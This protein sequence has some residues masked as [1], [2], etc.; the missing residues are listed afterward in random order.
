[1]DLQ[2]VAA[3]VHV[4]A[5]D[6][7]L[8]VEASGT[9]KRR[10]EYVGA[11]RRGDEDYARASF[12][13]VHLDEQL[14]QRLLAFV[15]S[16]AEAG[17]AVASHRVYFV[18]EYYAGL[19]FARLLE[20]VADARRADADEHFDEVGAADAEEGNVG[21]ARDGS[22]KERLTRSGS[23]EQKHA[24]RH[25]RAELREFRGV[26]EELHDLFKLFLRFV[27]SGDVVEGHLRAVVEEKLRLALREAHDLA[28][29][30]LHV[31]DEVNPDADEQ[32]RRE[33]RREQR[34]Q[35]RVL[36][37]RH[38]LYLHALGG[39]D[40][41][42][43]RGVEDEGLELAAGL[44]RSGE[45]FMV[46]AHPRDVAVVDLVQHRAVR[47]HV[48]LRGFLIAVGAEEYIDE[49]DH[50]HDQHNVHPHVL[51]NFL[52]SMLS[53]LSCSS[54]FIN[55]VGRL[56]Y[57][58]R[59]ELAEASRIVKAVADDEFVRNGEAGIFHLYRLR[60]ALRLI[61]QNAYFKRR[62]AASAEQLAYVIQ[63][64]PCVEDVF[65]YHDV[66]AADVGAEVLLYLYDAAAF[67][68]SAVRSYCEEV[69]LHVYVRP[70]LAYKVGEEDDRALQ[71]AYEDD[72]LSGVVFAYPGSELFNFFSY[73]LFGYKRSAYS[74][75]HSQ[76][77]PCGEK[78]VCNNRE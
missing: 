45:L 24:A 63:R 43:R 34:R 62:G 60:A 5:V 2:N 39:E 9:Q 3:S 51:R 44:Q 1:M 15:V 7:D 46:D 48:R 74:I 56:R 32:E 17:S 8:A 58:Y 61:E 52:Q 20:E 59:G 38:D 29:A 14:V 55:L 42:Q 77:L 75:F 31:V 36:R 33:Q 13:A 49:A 73:F 4:G 41:G 69:E 21:L 64:E 10:V 27:A 65:D 68:R 28:A 78:S 11:V 18:Y 70:D 67:R 23:A 50:K 25:S 19:I 72:L 40:R 22:R 6:D 66:L 12:K 71:H 47:H 30:A 35:P 54:F 26:F 16:A 53:S 57:V 37:R 76:A